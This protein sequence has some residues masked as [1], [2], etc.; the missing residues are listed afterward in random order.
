VIFII[1]VCSIPA[2]GYLLVQNS[3]I[4]NYLAQ[5]TATKLSGLFET[6]VNVGNVHI[7]MLNRL[8]INDLYIED[9][10]RDT[11]IF[12]EKLTL[13]I[14]AVNIS[15][16]II[17]IDRLELKKAFVKFYI[18][19]T[20][21]INLQ[22]FIKKLSGDT[23]KKNKGWDIMFNNI[24][25][26]DS[27]FVLQ[28]YF[29]N[30]ID[31][32]IN[33]TDLKLDSLNI[34]IKNLI[35][36]NHITSFKINKLYFKEHSGFIVNN[37]SA[38]MSLR[39]DFMH[40]DN[41]KIN[42]HYSKLDIP[43]AYF[44]FNKFN[45]FS[46]FVQ[47]VKLN[48][49]F[50][51]SVSSCLDLAYFIRGLRGF[52]EKFELEG[53]V[54]G[55]FNNLKC[56]KIKFSLG[57]NTLFEGDLSFTGL[58]VFQE[59]YMYIN[60]RNLN[61]SFTDVNKIYF[62][63]KPG[64]KLNLPKQ[65]EKIGN[66]KYKGNF[67][68]FV[69]DFVT[70]GTFITDFGILK[71][72]FSLKPESKTRIIFNG[73]ISAIDFSVGRFIENEKI[74]GMA[75]INLNANGIIENDKKFTGT[76]DGNVNNFDFYGYKYS[77]I[78]LSG[79][80][81]E[82]AFD[83]SVK[84][85]DPHVKLDL[86]GH[87]DFTKE[88]PEFDFSAVLTNA[89]LH[90]LHII[91]KDSVFDIS[92][93]ANAK[94]KGNNIDN[95]EGN[96]R[97]QEADIKRDKKELL[98]KNLTIYS[99][100][101][102]LSVKS[103]IL[104][105]NIY[106]DHDMGLIIPSIIKSFKQYMPSSFA[107]NKLK[108]PL[109]VN[110][111]KFDI[112]FKNVKPF[113]GFFKDDVD[114]AGN[115]KLSGTFY[116][117]DSIVTVNFGADY[118]QIGSNRFENLNLRCDGV[119]DSLK[120]SLSSNKFY[121]GKQLS[122]GY[123][124]AKA[125]VSNDSVFTNIEWKNKDSLKSSSNITFLAYF[126][127]TGK[128]TFPA[129]NIHLYPAEIY[130]IDS[131]WKIDNSKVILDSSSISVSYFKISHNL[132]ELFAYGKI[133]ENA[134]D[135]LNLRFKNFELRNLG[136]FLKSNQV[137]F[138]G[139]LSGH[140]NL[141]DYF[142]KRVFT[143]NLQI[144]DLTFNGEQLGNMNILVD[145]INLQQKLKAEANAYKTDYRSLHAEGEY[146][147]FDKRINF[148][149]DL[150]KINVALFQPFL[151]NTFTLQNGI[152][153]GH[154]ELT[155]NINKPVLNGSVGIDDA[156][157]R[158]NYL[159]TS[160]SFNTKLKIEDNNFILSNVKLIDR[161]DNH[162][163]V[164]GMI[165][166]NYFKSFNVN[167]KINLDN[168]LVLNTKSNDNPFYYGKVFASG[169][170]QINGPTQSINIDISHAKT[171]KNT[172]IYIPLTN[173]GEIS[174]NRFL[175]FSSLRNQNN[176][177]SLKTSPFD[178]ITSGTTLRLDLEITP[179]AEIQ[180]V[181]DPKVGDILRGVGS[182]NINIEINSFGNFMIRGDYTVQSGDY[183][184]TLQ[185]LLNKKFVLEPGGLISWNGNPMDANI[186]IKAV[187]K[188]R[189][190]LYNLILDP[191]YKKRIPI[192]CQL[193]LKGKLMHPDI[194]YDIYL[195]NTV[196]ETRN[197]VKDIIN[198]DEALSMQF[199]MLL[200]TNNFMPNPDKSNT[201]NPLTASGSLISRD[202]ATTTSYEMLSNQFSNWI[203]QVS[204]DFD[205]GFSYRPGDK[206]M[207]TSEEVEV[208]LSTQLLNDRVSINGNLDVVGNQ[209]NLNTTGKTNS[210]AKNIVGD[211]NVDVKL[212]E[213]GKLKL[214]AFNRAN[215]QLI[216]EQAPYTQ[217]IGLLYRE[218][219]STFGEL[220]KRYYRQLLLRKQND[221]TKQSVDST[222]TIN[223]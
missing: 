20:K 27:R 41:L 213:N 148:L 114:L 222:K 185:N 136:F 195:P 21:V 88:I 130:I 165:T 72:D 179:D 145:W 173:K 196:E 25:L 118:L 146:F 159:K 144:N 102:Q 24:G 70:Y 26:I 131:L 178:P 157:F 141:S 160:Y 22:F 110:K 84:L 37:L 162:C 48:Y 16:K 201:S 39:Q 113:F 140:G 126:S 68:G 117:S 152:C 115:S 204:K 98:V 7:D 49:I 12:A 214:K 205:V 95:I 101:S 73:K 219:F 38:K 139:K 32:G 177:V 111:F 172:V 10:R 96:I 79:S 89:Q 30:K 71:S 220:A 56:K 33:F 142:H 53:M 35:T 8:V 221:T 59:A 176:N 163:L 66:I 76:F 108:E 87:F 47:K 19:S 123:L 171:D 63:K 31:S 216:F 4:Q 135:T 188:V 99:H 169:Y 69:N 100:A 125:I 94:F 133:S 80:L 74:F 167:F 54:K 191:E 52:R 149:V 147:P 6:R 62:P 128:N 5:T 82:N 103:D 151:G 129:F 202:I 193:F 127:R 45:D 182:G 1:A 65:L 217:G 55:R 57:E 105:A 90:K 50:N 60:V 77:D 212:T 158:L 199:L 175:T 93:T 174:E 51:H 64:N 138:E 155:G 184:F 153:T 150:N 78:S 109:T 112:V 107:R 210:N 97:L 223:K 106:G 43:K 91:Q 186:D 197:K 168:T 207:M 124:N 86:S 164:N 156:K 170:V 44:D 58:P 92:C 137:K 61:I 122:F 200:V 203:S 3:K 198:N 40:F 215:D 83:G 18:D 134:D 206:T 17:R 192:E 183:L 190:S 34:R 132:Q 121:F 42:T 120:L 116:P 46:N 189:A 2:I 211:V 75:N 11:L 29:K 9:L 143:A 209:T 180:L 36:Q 161:Y 187:Y 218:D 166:N 14:G 23:A 119:K 28:N 85:D 15:K 81:Q 104:D 194:K 13:S 208:A 154:V 181:F 67:T